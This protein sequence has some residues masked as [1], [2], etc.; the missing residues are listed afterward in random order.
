M[1]ER[2]MSDAGMRGTVSFRRDAMKRERRPRVKCRYAIDPMRA[3]YRRLA[4]DGVARHGIAPPAR[5]ELT[6]VR[7]AIVPSRY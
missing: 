5:R 7:F 6:S 2:N 3:D 4:K 1:V